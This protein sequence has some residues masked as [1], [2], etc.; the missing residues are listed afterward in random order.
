MDKN[1]SVLLVLFLTLLLFPF[2]SSGRMSNSDEP[3]EN[4]GIT[5][6][7]KISLK[8]IGTY[9]IKMGKDS[10]DAGYSYTIGWSGGMERDGDDFLIYWKNTDLSHWEIKETLSNVYTGKTKTLT[11]KDISE[12]PHFM[13]DY[14]MD[15]EKD[16]HV[17]FYIEG[18]SIPLNQ[19]SQKIYFHLPE[20]KENS[21]LFHSIDYNLYVT[22]GI[23]IVSIK[24][25]KIYRDKIKKNFN[26]KWKHEGWL[27]EVTKPVFYFHNHSVEIEVTVIP[28]KT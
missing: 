20:T 27:P 4:P 13:F 1:Y 24:K 14:L 5:W 21:N 17:N 6:E 8:S 15:E 10:Y 12:K 9:R 23:N 2:A 28:K 18:F 26:W 7:M 3:N 19:S 25:N 16:V 22:K 11:M